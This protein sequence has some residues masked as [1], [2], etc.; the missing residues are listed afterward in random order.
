LYC[1][2]FDSANRQSITKQT[3]LSR[4]GHFKEL[5]M[6]NYSGMKISELRLQCIQEHN[7]RVKANAELSAYKSLYE[8]TEKELKGY[9]HKFTVWL[10]ATIVTAGVA[11]LCGCWVGLTAFVF[12]RI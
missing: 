7:E 11:F 3:A 12:N 4:G 6:K 1:Q 2:L 10:F 8:R 5:R 9:K